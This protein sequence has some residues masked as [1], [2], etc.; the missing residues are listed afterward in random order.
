MQGYGS[1]LAELTALLGPPPAGGETSLTAQGAYVAPDRSLLT[2]D[3]GG[4]TVSLTTIGDQ[5]W[6]TI[7]TLTVGPT[8]AESG[9]AADLSLAAMILDSGFGD[10]ID[11]FGCTDETAVINGEPARRCGISADEAAAVL[12]SL[13]GVFGSG[14][15]IS[16]IETFSFEAW[17]TTERDADYP[18]RVRALVVGKDA[19]GA[20]LKVDL[21]IE[22]SDLNAPIDIQ[23]PK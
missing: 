2:I 17:L 22:V 3:L 19:T 23:P 1:Y 6:T 8:P 7:G 20:D 21:D 18:V 16:A 12:P 10:L 13:G 15:G 9:S 4:E 5:Q 14:S 11:L